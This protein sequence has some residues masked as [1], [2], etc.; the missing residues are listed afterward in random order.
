MVGILYFNQ[1]RQ[2]LIDAR[3]QSLTTQAHII[4]AAIAGSATVDTGSIVI[5]PDLLDAPPDD[6]PSASDQINALDFPINPETA[7]PILKRLLSNTTVR[8]RIIDNDGNMVVDSR[9]L[10]W[11]KRYCAERAAVNRCRK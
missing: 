5:D 4:S 7:G 2:G 3:V 10:I 6:G 11:P 8:A 9:F 1:F